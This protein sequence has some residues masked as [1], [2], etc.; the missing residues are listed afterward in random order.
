[1]LLATLLVFYL[2][3]SS[4]RLIGFMLLIWGLFTLHLQVRLATACKNNGF[5]NN[6][7]G[8]LL[9]GLYQNMFRHH[10]RDMLILTGNLTLLVFM[11]GGAYLALRVAP[12]FSGKDFTLCKLEAMN[13]FA[14]CSIA[15]LIF[16]TAQSFSLRRRAAVIILCCSCMATV[17]LSFLL[18]SSAEVRLHTIP[19]SDFWFNP[20]ILLY[21]IGFLCAGVYLGALVFRRQGRFIAL[22]ALPLAALL[23]VVDMSFVADPQGFAIQ[24]ACWS[25]MGAGWAQ[26]WPKPLS[27]SGEQLL[28][29][30]PSAEEKAEFN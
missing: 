16:W 23:A 2:F 4:S 30:S 6:L 17:T 18:L 8:T 24:L 27:A 28:N 25:G 22:T 3:P 9:L 7:P 26:S 15:G 11:L 1:M 10:Q 29:M 12:C 14:R 13:V 19:T 5:A 21:A 20:K